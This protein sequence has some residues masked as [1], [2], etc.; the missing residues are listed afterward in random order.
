MIK[1]SQPMRLNRR[2]LVRAEEARNATKEQQDVAEV[3]KVDFLKAK[4][5]AEEAKKQTL[6]D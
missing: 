3:S 5:V 4:K 2:A 1:P 6:Q